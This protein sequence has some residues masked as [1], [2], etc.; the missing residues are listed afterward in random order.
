MDHADLSVPHFRFGWATAL[1]TALAVAALALLVDWTEVLHT[2][3][4]TRI[5]WLAAATV[6]SLAVLLLR[7]SRLRSLL[8]VAGPGRPE[9][10]AYFRATLMHQAAFVLAPSGSGD[11]LLPLFTRMHLGLSL[12]GTAISLVVAR[13]FDAISLLAIGGVAALFIWSSGPATLIGVCVVALALP[14]VFATSGRWVRALAGHLADRIRY[15]R[16]SKAGE[17]AVTQLR[18]LEEWHPGDSRPALV[19]ASWTLAIWVMATMTVWC[20]FQALAQPATVAEAAIL[21]V[22]LNASGAVAVLTVAGLGFVDA[23]LA[24]TLAFLDIGAGDVLTLTVAARALLLLLG[25]AFPLL[26]ELLLLSRSAILSRTT[27]RR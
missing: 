12:R 27:P 6:S 17:G 24:A 8:R 1:I 20:I 11:L 25:A 9:Y 23:G 26:L 2:L 18:I 13:V 15:L 5:E 16:R 7:A 4:A 22:A 19:V 3:R 10:L 14:V 21:L